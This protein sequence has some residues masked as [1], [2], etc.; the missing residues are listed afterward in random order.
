MYAMLMLACL[1]PWVL[2]GFGA[3]ISKRKPTPG[4]HV[5]PKAFPKAGNR[6]R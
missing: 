4:R 6:Y 1:V 2:I 3:M 5:S